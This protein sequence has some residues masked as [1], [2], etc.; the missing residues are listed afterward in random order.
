MA[1]RKHLC[2]PVPVASCC[3]CALLPTWTPTSANAIAFYTYPTRAGFLTLRK[4]NQA[5]GWSA[6]R[7]AASTTVTAVPRVANKQQ[8]DARC[9]VLSAHCTASKYHST[10]ATRP[11]GQITLLADA[12][13]DDERGYTTAP[14]HEPVQSEARNTDHSLG[15]WRGSGKPSPTKTQ[16]FGSND[17]VNRR[18]GEQRSSCQCCH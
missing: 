3:Q 2:H 9:A 17:S 1:L 5:H 8:D 14:S 16:L 7:S 6:S 11:F 13:D 12:G 10:H 4:I 18:V 15:L